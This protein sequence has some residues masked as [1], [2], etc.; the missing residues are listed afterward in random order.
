MR[1][2]KFPNSQQFYEL[3]PR[4]LAPSP[5]LFSEAFLFPHFIIHLISPPARYVMVTHRQ[6][7][8]QFLLFSKGASGAKKDSKCALAGL[9]YDTELR[10]TVAG[11]AFAV[12]RK[13]RND[14]E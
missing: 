1:N 2:H 3:S 14:N 5:S 8:C 12:A 9:I 6:S 7:E 10:S 4:F 13:V 11:G